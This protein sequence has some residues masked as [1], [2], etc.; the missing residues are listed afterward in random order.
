MPFPSSIESTQNSH[1]ATNISTPTEPSWCDRFLTHESSPHP[2]STTWHTWIHMAPR[3]S[4]WHSK[5]LRWWPHRPTLQNPKKCRCPEDFSRAKVYLKHFFFVKCTSE[6]SKP[7]ITLS[8]EPGGFPI[9]FSFSSAYPRVARV[10]LSGQNEDAPKSLNENKPSTCKSKNVKTFDKKHTWYHF[11]RLNQQSFC[12]TSVAFNSL[13]SFNSSPAKKAIATRRPLTAIVRQVQAFRSSRWVELVEGLGFDSKFDNK[14]C[15]RD[16]M[17]E[18]NKE[19]DCNSHHFGIESMKW[20]GIDKLQT[21]TLFDIDACNTNKPTRKM[22]LLNSALSAATS[23]SGSNRAAKT[24]DLFVLQTCHSLANQQRPRLAWTHLDDVHVLLQCQPEA[25]GSKYFTGAMVEKNDWRIITIIAV[26]LFATGLR[27]LWAYLQNL[28]MHQ[29]NNWD[30]ETIQD[31]LY[32]PS[33]TKFQC[34]SLFSTAC[35]NRSQSRFF[36]CSVKAATKLKYCLHSK[37]NWS[38]GRSSSLR[39]RRRF[40]C[41]VFIFRVNILHLYTNMRFTG[42]WFEPT[43][44]SK[45]CQS[46]NTWMKVDNIVET[47]RSKGYTFDWFNKYKWMNW[48]CTYYWC[49]GFQLKCSFTKG[50]VA[51]QPQIGHLKLKTKQLV[52]VIL[53]EASVKL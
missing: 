38:I 3:S 8:C 6:V 33:P 46:E 18:C 32:K 15:D 47:A 9:P 7:W 1:V 48:T 42:G 26:H 25:T 24:T 16:W 41:V 14:N 19:V 36:S 10:N 52:V 23:F 29:C 51:I 12:F 22:H 13:S 31:L 17:L 44:D 30:F 37:L 5:A 43:N 53:T 50:K 40:Q 2:P 49:E 45:N 4:N 21:T 35:K 11:K 28:P 20:K 39:I 27:N 34:W